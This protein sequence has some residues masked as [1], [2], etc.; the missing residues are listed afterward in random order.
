MLETL[1]HID[2]SSPGLY[3]FVTYFA[4]SALQKRFNEIILGDILLLLPG[5]FAFVKEPNLRSESKINIDEELESLVEKA[6]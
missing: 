3:S 5:V 4:Q 1:T 6:F 2:I